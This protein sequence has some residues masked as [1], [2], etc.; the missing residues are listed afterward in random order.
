[1]DIGNIKRGNRSIELNEALKVL[2]DPTQYTKEMSVRDLCILLKRRAEELDKAR[3]GTMNDVGLTWTKL[4]VSKG[5]K[6]LS[7]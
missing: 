5:R 1:M 3:P 6:E 2:H 7:T 4:L